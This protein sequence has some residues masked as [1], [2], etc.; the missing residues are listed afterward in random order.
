L[1]QYVGAEPESLRFCFGSHGKPALA[2]RQGEPDLHFNLAHSHQAVIYAF[3]RLSHIGIDLEY[4]RDLPD[5]E[6]VAASFFSARENAAWRALPPGQKTQGFFNC[7]T[8]KEAFVKA[9]GEGL[10][11]PLEA[12]DVA[13]APDESVRLLSIGGSATD[14]SRWS[15]WTLEPGSGYVAALAAPVPESKKYDC[16]LHLFDAS[17]LGS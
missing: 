6:Q 11:Y 10:S 3:A 15:L 16:H 4:L 17:A 9:I 13:L 5:A 12:F 1:G 7:W 2:S 14:A 8:R